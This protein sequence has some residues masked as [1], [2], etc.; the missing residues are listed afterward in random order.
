MFPRVKICAGWVTQEARADVE[1][2]PAKYPQTIKPFTACRFGFDGRPT[3][4]AGAA[5]QIRDRPER[6]AI[7]I[8]ERAGAAG[9]EVARWASA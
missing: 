3:R 2:D 5:R 7:N 1:V 9:A 4:L 8:L 6:S